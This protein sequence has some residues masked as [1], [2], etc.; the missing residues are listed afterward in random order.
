MIQELA[1]IGWLLL[2][3]LFGA[4]VPIVPTGAAVSGAAALAFHNQP[5]TVVLVV[6]AGA[7]G[8]YLGDLVVYAMCRQGGESLARRLRWL[9]DEDRLASVKHRLEEKQVPVLL[10]SRLIPGGRVPV[11]LAAAFVGL[12]WRTFVVA[13]AP[14]CALWSV[15]YAAIGLAGGSIFPEPWQ[16]VVAAV[17][18]I[19]IVNQSMTWISKWREAR[20]STS[21]A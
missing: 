12:P 9:R 13:N 7:I 1:T 8:A 21:E 16:G 2:V 10:V 5:L 20:A 14:A 3:V 15:V 17:V 19:L 11:L 18:L 6:A 4:I